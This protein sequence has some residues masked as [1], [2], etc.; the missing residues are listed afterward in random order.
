MGF[1]LVLFGFVLGFF[2]G[3]RLAQHNFGFDDKGAEP[4]FIDQG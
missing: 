1:F 2:V 3:T 4:T